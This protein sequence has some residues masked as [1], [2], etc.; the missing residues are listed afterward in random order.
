MRPLTQ[1]AFVDEDDRAPLFLGFF[2]RVGQVFFF[3]LRIASSLRSRALPTGR[4]GLQ[5]SARSSFQ[6]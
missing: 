5:F 4:C 2:L 1:S 6:T 3:H